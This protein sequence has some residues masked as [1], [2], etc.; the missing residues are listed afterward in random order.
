MI[1]RIIFMPMVVIGCLI[2][3][4]SNGQTNQ[5]ANQETVATNKVSWLVDFA[6]CQSITNLNGLSSNLRVEN[7]FGYPQ[8]TVDINN[9]SEKT[10][11]NCWNIYQV[12]FLKIDLLNMEGKPVKKTALGEQ[13]GAILSQQEWE[14]LAHDQRVKWSSGRARTYGFGPIVAAHDHLYDARFYLSDV[15]ELEQAGQYTLRVQIPIIQLANQEFI[16]T[17]LPEVICRIQIRA[18]D[19]SS[20]NAL[21]LDQTNSSAK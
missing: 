7:Y 8:C 15:F 16:T 17:W 10:I 12:R 21:S 5:V 13:C 2:S 14:A 4:I 18:S 3:N 11:A 9:Q 19:I 6:V 1:Q 20:T